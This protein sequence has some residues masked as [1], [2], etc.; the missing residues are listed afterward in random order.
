MIE[1]GESVLLIVRFFLEQLGKVFE[2]LNNFE[3]LPGISYFYFLLGVMIISI[4][5]K[6][7]RFGVDINTYDDGMGN[8]YSNVY[9]KVGLGHSNFRFIKSNKSKNDLRK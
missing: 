3:I 5:V 1:A 9:K 8:S 7:V 6:I 2:I 4:L